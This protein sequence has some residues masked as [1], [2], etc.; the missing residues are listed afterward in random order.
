MEKCSDIKFYEDPSS[1]AQLL[2]T[3]GR[4]DMTKLIIPFRNFANAPTNCIVLF[5][6]IFWYSAAGLIMPPTVRPIKG[7][8]SLR[9]IDER[10][11]S[12]G[13]IITDKG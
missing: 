12:A 8:A 2:Q 7:P 13:G 10:I 3:H 11:Q 9:I 5:V 1:G 4:T 6:C